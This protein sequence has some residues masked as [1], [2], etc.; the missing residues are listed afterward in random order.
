MRDLLL[1]DLT[2]LECGSRGNID[3]VRIM[4]DNWDKKVELTDRADR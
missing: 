2:N 3:N 1:M 4:R